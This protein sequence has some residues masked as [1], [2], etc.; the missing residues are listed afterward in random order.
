MPAR[1]ITQRS[2]P[3]AK[4]V[5]TASFDGT[6]RMWDAVTGL[7]LSPPLRHHDRVWH[8]EF[9][10]D[11][12]RVLTASAD[13]TA[14]LWPL[15]QNDWP[16]ADLRLLAQTVAGRL[17]DHT[18]SLSPLAPEALKENWRK[19]QSRYPDYFRDSPPKRVAQE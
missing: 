11:G 16:V 17:I 7:S 18:G 6:A 10:P 1:S 2:V 8:A 4:R 19:L 9:S 3:T 12:N 15:A 5:V 14:R 13:G